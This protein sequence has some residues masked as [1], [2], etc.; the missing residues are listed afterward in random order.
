MHDTSLVPVGPNELRS[1]G[2]AAQAAALVQV[3]YVMAARLPRDSDHFRTELLHACK[4]KG[5][6]QSARYSKP[7]GR[8]PVT[9]WSIRFV[10]TANRLFKNLDCTSRTLI[11]SADKLVIECTA[12]DLESNT[13]W[14]E[15]ISISKTVERR[16]T[17]PTH[18]LVG[19]RLNSYG[20]TVYI[21]RATDDELR[22]K[23]AALVSKTLR[24]LSLRL[25]PA[26]ILEEAEA[27]VKLT[28]SQAVAEDPDA[29]RKAVADAFSA[30]GVK[31]AHLAAHLGHPLKETTPAEL[32][33]LRYI[34]Q[35][36][37][38]GEAKWSDIVEPQDDD[39]PTKSER[40][41]EALKARR[42]KSDGK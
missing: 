32:M 38:S 23:V 41:K 40:T 18:E 34:Y 11:D 28:L 26:D 30:C 13:S 10:E 29:E 19:T 24:T 37:K 15:E 6:A 21:V 36:I 7:V 4:R 9:G 27:A 35:S 3:K 12:S 25:L 14:S 20:D 1:S 33:E 2:T 22:N 31:P 8:D 17:V 16:K 5:F 42:E 39:V